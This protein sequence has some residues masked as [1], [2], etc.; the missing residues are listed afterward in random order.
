MKPEM[1]QTTLLEDLNRLA[2]A[3]AQDQYASDPSRAREAL[4]SLR[5]IDSTELNRYRREGWLERDEIDMIERFLNFA[6]ERLVRI[7]GD[8]DP[9]AFTRSDPGWCSVRERALEI[10]I[11]LDG[12]V[13][14]GVPGWGQQYVETD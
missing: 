9:L 1:R 13:D 2:C 5:W 6:Q 12:F 14:I 7:P 10:V 4:N 11:A 3:E 8:S